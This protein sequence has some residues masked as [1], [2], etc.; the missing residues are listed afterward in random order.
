[1]ESLHQSLENGLWKFSCSAILL[2]FQTFWI[3]W[4]GSVAARSVAFVAILL[5]SLFDKLPIAKSVAKSVL[6]PIV[7]VSGTNSCFFFE[8]GRIGQ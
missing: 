2:I 4:I 5:T 7:S 6:A 3:L 1:M 8:R